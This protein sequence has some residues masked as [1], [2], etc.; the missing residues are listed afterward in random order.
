MN[1]KVLSI[2]LETIANSKLVSILPDIKPS[3]SLKSENYYAEE[4]TKLIE[5]KETFLRNN[6]SVKAI[7]TKIFK[8]MNK[9]QS[10]QSLIDTDIR[11]KRQAQVK[12]MGLDPMLNMIC[13]AGYYSEDISGAIMLEDETNEAEKHLINEFWSIASEYDHFVTF[14]GRKFDMKCLLVHGARERIFPS[15]NIDS[16]RYNKG[17]H[18]DLRHVFFGSDT[19][20]PGKLDFVSRYFLGHGKTEGINGEEIQDYWDIGLTE[21]ISDYCIEDC[22][23]THKLYRIA[24]SGGMLE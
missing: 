15:V 8:C 9:C 4:M 17:N 5:E 20:Q 3:K 24:E 13:C 6:R 1:K 19:F 2:D 16:G 14:N 12:K 11:E 18:T 21:D 10:A 22:R 23:I 7:E